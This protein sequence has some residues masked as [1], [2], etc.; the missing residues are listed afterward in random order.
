MT[1][2]GPTGTKLLNRDGPGMDS[3]GLGTRRAVPPSMT[4]E[5]RRRGRLAETAVAGWLA[6]KGWSILGNRVRVAGVE[7]DLVVE[8]DGVLA[9]VEVKARSHPGLEAARL[10]SRAQ[11]RRL[12]LA[13]RAIASRSRR[14]VLVRLDVAEVSWQ[15]GLP[16]INVH[17][18]A[19]RPGDDDWEPRDS[20]WG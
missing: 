7:V 12:C 3:G 14:D 11:R 4:Q 6:L 16:H 19:F 2:V 9:L 17:E 10:V 5:R 15:H 8:R 18:D 1:G 13:A 20:P